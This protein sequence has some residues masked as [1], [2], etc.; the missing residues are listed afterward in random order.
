MSSLIFA[1]VQLLHTL[2]T[3][4]IWIIII[5][6]LFSFVR[7]DP[8][9]PLVRFIHQITE[10]AFRWV[11]RQFPFVVISGMDLSPLVILLALQFADTFLM[12]AVY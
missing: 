3:I 2:I 4:Y 9:N 12:R 11:R 7:P 6:A 1:L 5:A 10:P 8:Y